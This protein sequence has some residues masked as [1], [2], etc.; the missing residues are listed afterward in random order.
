MREKLEM[1]Q[2]DA[3]SSLEKV[4]SL[5]QL[6]AIRIK[7]LG[8][9]GELTQVLRGM[10]KLSPEERP[11]I[12]QYANEVR[13]S[14]ERKL[15]EKRNELE[16]KALLNKLRK[17]ALDVTLP[18]RR[19]PHGKLHPIT[20]VLKQI[21]E[22]FLGMGFEVAEGPE[23]ELD[24]YNFEALNIPKIIQPGIPRIHSI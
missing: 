9:K 5:E 12:G 23:V 15:E 3:I 24:Y 1:I 19:P 22:I 10:G 11:I 8:K 13:T 18:G 4:D 7:Y 17:E 2:K 6:D 20:T 21:R 16:E 14:I